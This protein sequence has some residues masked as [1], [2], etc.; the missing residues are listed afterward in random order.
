MASVEVHIDLAQAG[1]VRLREEISGRATVRAHEH[2]K[3]QAVDVVV[4][5]HT[6]KAPEIFRVERGPT[7]VY[8][9]LIYESKAEP[10]E[11]LADNDFPAEFSARLPAQ[12]ISF[13]GKTFGIAWFVRVRVRLPLRPDV[14]EEKYFTV[15]PA[16]SHGGPIQIPDDEP[17]TVP[18]DVLQKN[19]LVPGSCSSRMWRR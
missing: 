14:R 1:P 8:E 4:G 18:L 9:K 13:Q 15:L 16:Q 19:G 12:P 7:M 5:F 3:C 17:L 10:K 2:M 11:L 6:T